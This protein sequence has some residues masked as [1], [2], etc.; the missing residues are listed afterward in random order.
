ML[1]TDK[2][3]LDD[4][5]FRHLVKRYDAGVVIEFVDQM[6][7]KSVAVLSGCAQWLCSVAEQLVCSGCATSVPWL[8][9]VVVISGCVQ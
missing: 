5:V 1:P 9:S 4:P 3:L 2:A 8:C 7:E 6:G